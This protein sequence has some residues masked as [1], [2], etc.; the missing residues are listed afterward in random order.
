MKKLQ[1]LLIISLV[2]CLPV[3][4]QEK[5]NPN[6]KH[7]ITIGYGYKMDTK[8][9]KKEFKNINFNVPERTDDGYVKYE[10]RKSNKLGIGI[11]F[12]FMDNDGNRYVD[13]L[14]SY[15]YRL[16]A[17][18]FLTFA[19]YYLLHSKKIDLSINA[20]LGVY[21]T[22]T[23]VWHKYPD[24]N[25]LNTLG[26]PP[27]LGVTDLISSTKHIGLDINTGLCMRY[28]FSTNIGVFF[29]TGN[30]KSVFQG[31]VVIKIQKKTF[32]HSYNFRSRSLIS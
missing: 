21:R 19:N 8:W 2:C 16:L 29:E 32:G 15:G 4:S 14:E 31:G 25:P 5:V 3:H 24:P 23:Q 6:K 13:W 11:E 17:L 9:W 30:Y 22:K 1:F 18:R 27:S 7:F 12:G 20:G 10:F 26:F 28:F